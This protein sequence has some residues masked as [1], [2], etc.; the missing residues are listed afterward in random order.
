ML[1]EEIKARGNNSVFVGDSTSTSVIV[2]ATVDIMPEG[3]NKPEEAVVPDA[4]EGYA[5]FSEAGQAPKLYL[6]GRDLR[7]AL[8]AVGWFIRNANIS[9]DTVDIPA[10]ATVSTAP[11]YPIRGHQLGFRN[12]ANS[13]DAWD[14]A[15]YEQYIRDCI[16]FGA[17][18]IELIPSLDPESKEGPVM[19]VPQRTMNVQVA[20]VLDHYGMDLWLFLALDG[21][22]EN[23]QEWRGE[24]EAR[25]SLFAAYPAIDHVM[26]PGGDPGHTDPKLLMPWLADL[27]PVLRKH[28]PKAGLWVSNQGFVPEQNDTFFQYL[29][30]ERP[31]WLTGVVFGP[32][33]KVG[34]EKVRKRTPLQY[35][36]RRYPDI[37]HCVRSQYPMPEWDRAF[38]QIAGREFTNPRPVDTAQTHNTL[39]PFANGFVAYSDGCHDDLNKMI[40]SA[41]AWDPDTNVQTVVEE[42]ARAFMGHTH[43]NDVAQGL[44]M[45]EANWRGNPLTNEGID[46]TL[47]HWL[48]LEERAGED[49]VKNWR[50]KLYLLRAI[51]DA[52]IRARLIADTAQERQVYSALAVVA[53]DGVESALATA[54]AIL[55]D[56]GAVRVRRDLR[57]RIEALAID[58]FTLRGMQYSV[59]EPYRARNAERG[60]ILDT[61]DR[62]LN[63][64]PW[65]MAQ[66]Q[67]IRAMDNESEQSARIDMLVNWESPQSGAIYDDLGHASNQVHLVRQLDRA[68]DPGFVR[69]TQEEHSGG[70]DK[71]SRTPN[72]RR[73]SWL[74]QAQTLFGT[75]LR[76]HYE[77][78]DPNTTY[79]IRVTYAGRFRPTMRLMADDTHQIHGPLAQTQPTWP[80]DFDLPHEATSDGVLDLE[81]QLVSGRGCQVAEVW[82]IPSR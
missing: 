6:I 23:A 34:L 77:N 51:C 71:M 37:T 57:A 29:K 42:Y 19:A 55:R 81:W 79:T 10:G 49:F 36:I 47:A 78:L 3:I 18:A 16:L 38:G 53:S 28:F 17:N 67:A 35:P 7:G 48:A 75:P 1:E 8:Y 68:T 12:T 43:A 58:L 60:A 54:E 25:D 74:D 33:T 56:E 65:L 11:R 13:Y 45:L 40:W 44:Y 59:Y 24:L 30:D 27:A 32:W 4:A 22:I 69:G 73:L 41:L 62:P 82:L 61:I 52:Y 21:H 2:V 46:A 80:V 20:D 26:V 63:D 64:R 15:G 76:M 5:V 39:A 31:N 50:F 66:F 14:L 9:P 70:Q 72:N